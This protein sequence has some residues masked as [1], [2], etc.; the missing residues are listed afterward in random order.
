MKGFGGK[1][2]TAKRENGAPGCSSF[3]S[4][5][6]KLQVLFNPLCEGVHVG[7]EVRFDAGVFQGL[8]RFLVERTERSGRMHQCYESYPG[9]LLGDVS[10][11]GGK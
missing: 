8:E 6:L 4:Q 1:G 11:D 10:G 7:G 2:E 5:L 9:V 3:F